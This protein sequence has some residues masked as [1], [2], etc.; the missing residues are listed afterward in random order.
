MTFKSLS[1]HFLTLNVSSSSVITVYYSSVGTA[2]WIEFFLSEWGGLYYA[3]YL[4]LD[5]FGVT[6]IEFFF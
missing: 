3:Y 6:L 4:L 5:S 2:A 1:W